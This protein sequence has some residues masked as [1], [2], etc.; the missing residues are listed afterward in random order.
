MFLRSRSRVLVLA[1]AVVMLAQSGKADYLLTLNLSPDVYTVT[2]GGQITLS[3]FFTTSDALTFTYDQDFLF[4]LSAT[5]PHLGTVAG[6]V[7]SSQDF[8]PPMDGAYFEDIFGGAGYLGPTTVTGPTVTG[9]SDLRTFM[10]PTDT[11]M[12]F[13]TTHT[14]LICSHPVTALSCLMRSLSRSSLN[15]QVSR[16]LRV[17]SVLRR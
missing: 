17:A 14:E 5:S 16:Y 12:E 10:I 8:T 13:T 2:A 11:Q 6:S 3:G 9:V 1:S 4:G 7:L 15:H